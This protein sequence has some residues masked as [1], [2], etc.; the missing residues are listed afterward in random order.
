M[1]WYIPL[2]IFVARIGDV[3]LGT[4]RVITVIRGKKITSALLGVVE[5]TLWVLAVGAVFQYVKESLWALAAYAGGFGTGTLVGI[6]IEEKLA[7]GDQLVRVVN[8]DTNI[9]CIPFLREHGHTV[10]QVEASTAQGPAEVCFFTVPRKQS[11]GITGRILEHCP[12]ATVTL[13]DIR[14]SG[15][16]ST[17]HRGRA[18]RRSPTHRVLKQR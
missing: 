9:R 13:E 15:S 7:V 14:W 10:T 16:Y 8:N 2:V 12:D 1:P 3:S 6:W 5:V 18:S 17:F 4:I 11:R